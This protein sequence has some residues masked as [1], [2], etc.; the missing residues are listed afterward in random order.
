MK[1]LLA[2]LALPLL[3]M[4]S[5][6]A[7][8]KGPPPPVE[9]KQVAPG[10]A[11]AVRKQVLTAAVTAVDKAARTVTLK[12][13][14]G[15]TQTFKAG[16]EIQRFDEIAVGDT[17]RIEFQEGLALE[18]QP[19]GT[20]PVAPE[21]VVVADRAGKDQAPGAAAAAGVRAT[22]TVTAI[23]MKNRVVVFQGPGGNIYQVKAGPKIQLEKLKVGDKLLATYVEAVAM[24]LEKAPKAPAP[25]K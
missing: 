17:V 16:P 20:A 19:A 8:D 12:G 10:K 2:L 7:Q 13:P 21:A 6:Q 9:V 4:S 18:F 22:V 14:D 25:K 23:D 5:A 15:K 3:S 11:E 1:K 24:T